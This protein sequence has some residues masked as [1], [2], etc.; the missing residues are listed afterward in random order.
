MRHLLR[1]RPDGFTLAMLA[2]VIVAALLPCR[3]ALADGLDAGTGGA[4]ALLFFLHGARLPREAALAG[5]THWR[6]HG[7]V[8]VGS[9]V[10]FP[11]L[12]LAL[13]PLSPALL[14]RPLYL[15]VL[16]LTT[17]PSTIQASI[18]FTSIAGG[19]VPAA[20]CSASASSLLG[21]VITP[22]LVGL[23]MQAHG[24]HLSLNTIEPIALQLLL[25]FL[26]G[27]LL[28]RRIGGWIERRAGLLG[29]VDRG[30]IL[31]MVYT[32]F[33][34]ATVG[35]AWHQLPPLG[36]ALTA[37]VVGALLAIVLL[38]MTALARLLGFARAD[39]ITLVFCGSK[40]SLVNGIPM[41]HV[42]FAGQGVGLI[43]LPLMLFH[44]IQLVV[45]GALARR[46]AARHAALRAA[47]R[48]L[49]A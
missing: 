21:T 9:F 14:P 10:L 5:L 45:C 12:G 40:K 6:L 34:S 39:E 48:T 33:S 11:L 16:F 25:P 20:I 42:L 36:L 35:G 49:A 28:R 31:L 24:T 43:V 27:Q 7:A 13:A 29:L 32:V 46:Y 17:L 37:L 26:A 22:L 18:A 38:V 3:G 4:I 15:G 19:N 2:T 8:L 47:P 44:Q 41:A 1:F 23:L 30:A